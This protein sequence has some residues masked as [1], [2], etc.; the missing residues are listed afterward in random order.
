MDIKFAD[1]VT[2]GYQSA[3]KWSIPDAYYETVWS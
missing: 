2:P 3:F 1:G